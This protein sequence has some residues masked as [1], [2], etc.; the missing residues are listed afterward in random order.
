M[1]GHS[2]VNM[3]VSPSGVDDKHRQQILDQLE[4]DMFYI[5]MIWNK[6]LTVHTLVYDMARNV[7]YEDKDVDVRLFGG[8]SMDEFLDDARA[9]V[10]KKTHRVKKSNG[11][12]KNQSASQL[13]LG[14]DFDMFGDYTYHGMYDQF[15]LGGQRWRL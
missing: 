14:A 9:K 10:Q 15:D 6:S 3:G 12:A 13:A 2:H 11:E 4:K 1:Q 5:F 8:E 7:L